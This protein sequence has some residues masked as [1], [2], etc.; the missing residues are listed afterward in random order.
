PLGDET[1]ATFV[2]LVATGDPDPARAAAAD[3]F[4]KLIGRCMQKLPQQHREILTLRN[5][6]HHSYAEIAS[7]LGI[8]VGTVKSRIARA[9]ER[10]R[11][12]LFEMCPEFTS[13]AVPNDWF[14]LS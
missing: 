4:C 8:S 11:E 3:E 9:R 1:V 14:E 5:V 12:L 7:T 2:D 6:L 10:V 13:D